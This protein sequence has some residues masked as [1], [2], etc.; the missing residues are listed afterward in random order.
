MLP[1]ATLNLAWFEYFRR[2]PKIC[3]EPLKNPA[4]CSEKERQD[5]ENKIKQATPKA[6]RH[7]F[8]IR[9]GQYVYG[10]DDKERLLTE[11]G[12]T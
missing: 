11:L 10:K 8:L 6:T 5:H 9:H 1:S 2:D 3:V 12:N 4:T 7:L